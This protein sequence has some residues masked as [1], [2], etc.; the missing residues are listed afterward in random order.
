[1]TSIPVPDIKAPML[2]IQEQGSWVTICPDCQENHGAQ[3]PMECEIED[4]Q[5][6]FR[7][8][9]DPLPLLVVSFRYKPS[10]WS[11]KVC[12]CKYSEKIVVE[13]M[14]DGKS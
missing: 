4:D 11:C 14:Q 13:K 9:G 6:V 10:I 2:R 7:F 12:G 8:P 3:N 1:V 5:P